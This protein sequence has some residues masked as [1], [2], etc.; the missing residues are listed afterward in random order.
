[1]DKP[2]LWGT[3]GLR[4]AEKVS[5]TEVLVRLSR[6]LSFLYRPKEKKC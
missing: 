5:V 1:M 6:L 4:E 2:N 3:S